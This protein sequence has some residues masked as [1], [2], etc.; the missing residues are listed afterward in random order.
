M[1]FDDF[2]RAMMPN[3]VKESKKKEKIFIRK[4]TKAEVEAKKEMNAQAVDVESRLKRLMAE[5]N[6]LHSKH[7]LLWD[8]ITSSTKD[9]TNED[10]LSLDLDNGIL[11]R[12]EELK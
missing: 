12:Y 4:L 10:E 7:D 2:V 11:Y 9:I 8:D 3:S 6:I 1:D 5:A